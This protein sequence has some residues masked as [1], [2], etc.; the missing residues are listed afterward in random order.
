MINFRRI[1]SILL[2][3]CMTI[4]MVSIGFAEQVEDN[5]ASVSESVQIIELSSQSTS[6]PLKQ[7]EITQYIEIAE[8]IQ[9]KSSSG[10]EVC[11]ET[12]FSD[13]ATT[14]YTLGEE[15]TDGD[16]VLQATTYSNEDDAPM[17]IVS[18]SEIVLTEVD[19]T[20]QDSVSENIILQSEDDTDAVIDE[21][22]I[23]EEFE[24]TTENS[25]DD[26]VVPDESVSI[27]DEDSSEISSSSEKILEE[28]SESANNEMISDN[29]QGV[30][31][32]NTEA[33]A[34]IEESFANE[35]MSVF[36]NA[37]DLSNVDAIDSINGEE[38]SITNE[39]VEGSN[40]QIDTYENEYSVGDATGT[41]TP[42]LS[43]ITIEDMLTVLSDKENSDPE[44]YAIY[45]DLAKSIGL[46]NN[47]KEVASNLQV[48]VD[49]YNQ[50]HAAYEQYLLD[51]AAYEELLKTDPNAVAP[52]EVQDPT[53]PRIEV[54]GVDIELVKNVETVNMTD[55]GD[56]TFSIGGDIQGVKTEITVDADAALTIYYDGKAEITR[57]VRT[58]K[59]TDFVITLDVSGSMDWDGRYSAMTK[60]LNVLLDEIMAG[61]ENT[62]S[63]VCWSD[64]ASVVQLNVNG[65]TK[66]RFSAEDG[67]SAEDIIAALKQPYG[68]T[69]PAAGLDKAYELLS[70]LRQTEGTDS[71][72]VRNT[73]VLLFTDGEAN[74]SSS[75]RATIIDEHKLYEEFGATVV[76]VSIGDEY[77]VKQYERYLDPTSQNYNYSVLGEEYTTDENAEENRKNYQE[78]VVYYNIPKL[79]DQELAD[80]VSELFETAFVE[81][82]SEKRQLQTETITDGVLAAVSAK[83]I[84]E[85]PAGF[86]LVEVVGETMSYKVQGV[87]SEGNTTIEFDLDDL[88][89]GEESTL[90]YFVVPVGE[91][92]NV[93]V[94]AFQDVETVLVAEPIERVTNKNEQK[95]TI[96]VVAT[97]TTSD[98]DE[99][100]WYP[101]G[102]KDDVPFWSNP[103][104]GTKAFED[105]RFDTATSDENRISGADEWQYMINFCDTLNDAGFADD[106]IQD[107]YEELASCKNEKMRELILMMFST[108][109]IDV[110]RKTTNDDGSRYETSSY[111]S[112]VDG[113]LVIVY[114]GNS[115]Q[116]RT[117]FHEIGHAI[118]AYAAMLDADASNYGMYTVTD[119]RVDDVFEDV[120]ANVRASVTEVVNNTFK[121][122]YFLFFKTQDN[123]ATRNE[124][125]EYLTYRVMNQNVPYAES[126]ESKFGI[127]F[128]RELEDAYNNIVGLYRTPYVE[129]RS[130]LPFTEGGNI[131]NF[132]GQD[133]Y[134][135]VISDVYG[136]V[137]N[138]NIVDGMG[139]A[140]QG[141][142]N[143]ATSNYWYAQDSNGNFIRDENGN[144]VFIPNRICEIWAEYTEC[145]IQDI[146]YTDDIVSEFFPSFDVHTLRDEMHDLIADSI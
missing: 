7:E 69:E 121:D 13:T 26:A 64:Y 98:V 96:A 94:T 113:Q 143:G 110:S 135:Y 114:N 49:D 128:T 27:P 145:I 120:E 137:T 79:T 4:S 16:I 38:E 29:D 11:E 106:F 63:I 82:V 17:P 86:E 73:G 85:I 126:A 75:E 57:K 61:E 132:A 32:G 23:G 116:V 117:I 34:D 136:G 19:P 65:E 108:D 21:N 134:K 97:A 127:T 50:A 45:Y 46:G 100:L 25:L 10:A 5:A 55:N 89:S 99:E 35:E 72:T 88:V 66:N 33:V 67:V 9:E 59:A 8:N 14:V 62:V 47:E 84:D 31:S 39:L 43:A 146:W 118:D 133:P 123:S 52:T 60:A 71:D 104:R 3:A 40:E 70:A 22:M 41:T 105:A 80:K 74:Y 83:L 90:S 130:L 91:N 24:E 142:W 28:M 56:G 112:V 124:Y 30:V 20:V 58:D 131:I 68:G 115:D 107:C 48:I 36:T 129:G 77:D 111:Q 15:S 125:I 140:V 138:N 18:Y 119:D 54:N 95:K 101:T 12:I 51:Y 122:D 92:A 81:I 109:L 53:V 93:G 44:E 76:N 1:L 103:F 42:T 37:K 144:G 139:H 6:E 2:V 102:S 78:K 87:D 141:N